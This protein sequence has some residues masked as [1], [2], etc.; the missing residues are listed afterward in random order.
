[1]RRAEGLVRCRVGRVLRAVQLWFRG[2]AAIRGG[3]RAFDRSLPLDL[4]HIWYTSMPL[5]PEGITRRRQ[6]VVSSR[7]SVVSWRGAALGPSVVNTFTYRPL[8]LRG[9]RRVSLGAVAVGRVGS[10]VRSRSVLRAAPWICEPHERSGDR[11]G[12]GSPGPR[13]LPVRR[14]AGVRR[15]RSGRAPWQLFGRSPHFTI[16]ITRYR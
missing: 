12:A 4:R 9:R 3:R 11:R 2:A 1:M 16:K 8:R 10:G 7:S 14:L 6:R 15:A 5:A 13:A